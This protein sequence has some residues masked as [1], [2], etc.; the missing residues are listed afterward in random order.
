M[1][2]LRLRTLC[3]LMLF[4]STIKAQQKSNGL[5]AQLVDET[6]DVVEWASVVLLSLPDSTI[7]GSARTGDN[8]RFL[9]ENITPGNYA[10]RISFIGFIERTIG[11]IKIETD[12]V[13]NLGVI[14]LKQDTRLLDEVVIERIVPAVQHELDRTIFNITAD[15]KGMSSNASEI[16]E[17]IPMVELNEDGV[18]SAM[19]QNLT[20][21]ID[22]RPS[23]VYGDNI[24]TVLKLIPSGIIEKVEVI[25]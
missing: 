14:T 1:R 20:V 15:I 13:N 3:T 17:Q 12:K 4:T 25:T 23:K 19:G 16:L 5:S 7:V 21:L 10:I 2:K 8:G 22:G 24:E 9:I 11:N 6:K 18:P